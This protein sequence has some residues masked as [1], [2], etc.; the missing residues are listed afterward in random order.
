MIQFN[1][2][3]FPNK[4]YLICQNPIFLKS[5]FFDEIAFFIVWDLV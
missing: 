4:K 2:T 1:T 5:I 3:L